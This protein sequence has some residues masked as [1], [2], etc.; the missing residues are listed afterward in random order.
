MSPEWNHPPRNASAVASRL[1]ARLP[2]SRAVGWQEDDP[3]VSNYLAANR[4]INTLSYAMVVAAI[5]VVAVTGQADERA[6]EDPIGEDVGGVRVDARVRAHAARTRPTLH[7][8]G[9]THLARVRMK[10]TA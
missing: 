8:N 5:A 3:F 7:R 4:T 10:I 6:D 9:G 1:E 2:A